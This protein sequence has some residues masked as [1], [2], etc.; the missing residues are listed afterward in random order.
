[1]TSYIKAIRRLLVESDF[2]TSK[3]KFLQQ[4]IEEQEIAVTFDSFKEAASKNKIKNLDEKNIDWWAK[5]PWAEFKRFVTE[6]S[7]SKTKGE[8]VK[9]KANDGAEIR[10]EDDNWV[11]YKILTK[12]ACIF[13]GTNKWCI[14][15]DGEHYKSYSAHSDFYFILSKTLGKESEW[16]KIALQVSRDTLMKTYWDANDK[17]YSSVPSNLNLPEFKIDNPLEFVEE[18]A[19]R[20]EPDII[21]IRRDLKRLARSYVMNY[22]D[23]PDAPLSYGEQESK[24][25]SLYNGW[26]QYNDVNKIVIVEITAKSPEETLLDCRTSLKN[27]NLGPSPVAYSYEV[28]SDRLKQVTRYLSKN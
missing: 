20:L 2:K 28:V 11:V 10:A 24:G 15:K 7:D 5:K 8:Q 27:R 22:S 23:H 16:S 6:L 17:S 14:S 9:T 19:K 4:G 1:M 12:D 26:V 13:Y 25:R 18:V 21:K 3:E